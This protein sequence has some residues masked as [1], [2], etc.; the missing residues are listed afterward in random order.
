MVLHTRWV[1]HFSRTRTTTRTIARGGGGPIA[2][3]APQLITDYLRTSCD[4]NRVRHQEQPHRDSSRPD[5]PPDLLSGRRETFGG[6]GCG[7]GSHRTQV[8]DPHD[9]EN[10]RQAGTAVTAVETEVQ[11]V[12]PSRVGICR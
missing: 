1:K 9:E 12:S 7:Y 4:P 2:L 11:A 10:H 6:D 8:H 3:L 5:G